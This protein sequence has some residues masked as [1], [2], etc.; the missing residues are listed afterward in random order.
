M[1]GNFNI[2]DALRVVIDAHRP[3][4]EMVVHEQKIE[5]LQRVFRYYPPDRY[6]RGG[7]LEYRT[8]Y[9]G[10]EGKYETKIDFA[11]PI[12]LGWR[13]IRIRQGN[14]IEYSPKFI[15]SKIENAHLGLIQQPLM[16]VFPIG[17]RKVTVSDPIVLLPRAPWQKDVVDFYCLQSE[18]P[19]IIIPYIEELRGLLPAEVDSV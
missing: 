9:N 10:Y 12:V 2:S 8:D 17:S 7:T 3:E 13:C 5:E 11:L 6:N 18:V 16:N 14:V 4:A 15:P 1:I 19:S